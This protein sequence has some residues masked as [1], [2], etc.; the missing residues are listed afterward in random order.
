[1]II[2]K[3][4]REACNETAFFHFQ[5]ILLSLCVVFCLLL[6]LPAPVQASQSEN[7]VAKSTTASKSSSSRKGWVTEDG[8]IS[9]RYAS[10]KKAVGFVKIGSRWYHFEKSGAMSTG[11]FQVGSYRYF[12][13]RTGKTGK[14]LGSLMT[15][16]KKIDGVYYSFN[17]TGRAGVIGRQKTGWITE[18]KY[19]FYYQSDGSKAFG[20]T[21]IGKRI[22]YFSETGVP[23][24]RGRLLT[25]WQTINGKKYYFRTSGKT[26]LYGAAYRNRTVK[27]KKKSYTFD[28]EGAL[29]TKSSQTS[30]TEADTTKTTT[31]AASAAQ[32]AFIEKI[33]AMAHADM[34]KTGVLASVTTA[35]AIVESNYGTSLLAVKANNLFGMKA[36]L[37]GGNWTS[38][39]DGS[40]YKK[41]TQE[42]KNGKYIT[43]TADFRKYASLAQ[44]IDDHSMYLAGAK[45]SANVLRYAGIVGEKDYKKAASI[46]KAGGYATAPNYVSALCAVIEKYNL[47]RFD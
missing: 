2:F 13:R 39:W 5:S 10:G 27:I 17:T 3:R 43:I 9:Y 34:E 25:D 23:K 45:K 4:S 32:L 40:I 36:N 15:G 41:K 8:I 38:V 29:V 11:W 26:G 6:L 7:T 18:G 47:T 33:G 35:Q 28:A 31:A 14:A 19:R 42:Y 12:A 44:S 46:I 22:F 21:K 24:V 1:M 20:L 37:S 16:F 30:S